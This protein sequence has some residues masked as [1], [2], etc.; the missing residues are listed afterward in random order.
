MQTALFSSL[1]AEAP[2]TAVS[3]PTVSASKIMAVPPTYVDLGK[4]ASDIFTKVLIIL[5][6]KSENELE[7][8]SSGSTNTE[9]I[10]VNDSLET[11]Y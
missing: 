6:K 7:F 8:T 3:A 2:A 11:K 9:T 1:L 4:A 5:E 10:K